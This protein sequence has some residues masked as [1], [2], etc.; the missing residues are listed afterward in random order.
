M[1]FL[2][3]ALGWMLM[4][5]GAQ[6]AEANLD[7]ALALAGENRAQLE[8]AIEQAPAAQKKAMQFLIR[9]MPERDLKSL[10]AD[11]LL[12]NVAWAYRARETFPWAKEVPEEIFF[13]D[14]LPYAALNERRDDW[15]EDFFNRFS[16]YVK[17]AKTQEEARLAVC[18][19]IKD[20]VKVKYSTKRN[21]ADQSPYE[22]METGLASCTGLSVL[23]NNAFRAV[24]IPSRI[25]G[26]PSWTTKRGNH[27]W[28]EIWT[29]HDRQWHFTEYYFDKKGLDRGW[30]L[31]DAARGN[32][33]SLYH[34]IYA[35]SWK[36]TGQHFPLVWDLKI[37]Y[38]H[39]V[40]V[41]DRYVQLGGVKSGED[42]CE[43]RIHWMK[44][45]ERVAAELRVVQ[46]D[47]NLGEGV[48]PKATDDMNRYFTV[49]ARKGQLY[50][51]AWKDPVSGKILQKTVKTPKEEAWLTVNLA[52]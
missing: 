48:S 26:T 21:K 33:Q 51:I 12:N 50:I 15:R 19:N 8:Q 27:N 5:L 14:V 22:S 3:G 36:P 30:F 42:V 10:K 4:I 40:N 32:A 16:K 35:S 31:A 9:Y 25:A 46:G 44:G 11:Y 17:G 23:L 38:V 49:K 20:E 39:A 47:V 6:A 34:S 7:K 29:T 43:L 28:V 1:K 52:E 45:G 13:N 37:R 18:Q 24:G 2:L 41:T